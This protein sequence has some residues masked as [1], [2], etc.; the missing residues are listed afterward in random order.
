MLKKIEVELITG[1]LSAGK[2]SFLQSFID[3]SKKEGTEILIIQ[4]E[5]GRAQLSDEL[6]NKK[7]VV[8][9]KYKNNQDLDYKSLLNNINFHAPK[10]IVIECNGVCNLDEFLSF[11]NSESLRKRIKVTG[12]ITVVDC[13]TMNMFLKNMSSLILPNLRAADLI[14]LNNCDSV[15]LKK[16]EE[17]EQILKDINLHAHILRCHSSINLDEDVRNCSIIKKFV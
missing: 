14:V 17:L 7:K 1:F 3:I 16:T 10:R 6:L 5:N 9:R 2:T 12:I 13:M 8:L 11:L 4:C 15:G